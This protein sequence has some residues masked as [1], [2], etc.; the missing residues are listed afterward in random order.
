M[1]LGFQT[2]ASSGA[3]P[4]WQSLAQGGAWDQPLMSVVLTRFN[5]NSN[6]N[7]EE[8]GGRF[9]MGFT[10]TSLYTGDIEYTNIPAGQ[11][12][13]WL[14]PVSGLKVNGNPISLTATSSSTSSSSA[15]NSNAAIDTGTTLIGG[16]SSI[17]AAIYA[18]IPNSAPGSGNY[19]GYYTY[20]CSTQVSSSLNFGGSDWNISPAD[21]QFG[22]VSRTE[23]LGAFFS[24]DTSGGP[25]WIV[26]D[27][28]LKNVYTVFRQNPASVGFAQ[29]SETSLAL[30]DSDTLPTNTI[31]TNPGS[32]TDIS[33][34]ALRAR[35]ADRTI[36]GLGLV[37]ILALF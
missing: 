23:C 33:S 37:M 14:I 26:G 1:G 30:D 34:S 5:N 28:F 21:F 9:T 10:N 22:Q 7:Q 16:P 13:F 27:T 19:E 24:I 25:S 2:I 11:Q 12:G 20:P 8:P 32:A 3:V 15:A 36:L 35:G 31:V 18:A 6:A 29:L 17:I 4:F